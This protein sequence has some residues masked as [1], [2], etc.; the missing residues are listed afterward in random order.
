MSLLGWVPPGFLLGVAL[1]LLLAQVFHA[2]WYRTTRRHYLAVLLLTAAGMLAGQAW[3][4]LGL[5]GIHLGQLNLLPAVLFAAALQPL[6]PRL[7]LR[8]P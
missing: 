4:A 1:T 5:P 6:A 2:G 3:D 7:T 8:L